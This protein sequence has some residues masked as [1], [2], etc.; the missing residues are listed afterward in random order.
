MADLIHTKIKNIIARFDSKF[1][2]IIFLLFIS[3]LVITGSIWQG[4][5]NN[6]P[7]HWGLMLSN[8]KDLYE[9]QLPYKDI[10]IQYGIL[11]TLVH[12]F[13][14]FIGG[15][16]LNTIIIITAIFYAIG[17]SLLY[18]L[19]L[20]IAKE[21]F[22]AVFVVII[23]FLIHPIA[24]YPWPNYIAFPLLILGLLLLSNSYQKPRYL[25]YSGFSFGL[26]ILA[27]ENLALPIILTLFLC[28]LLE[29][30]ES[31]I[32]LFEKLKEKLNIF[33]GIL[34]P[35]I[36]FLIYLFS[37]ELFFY[38]TK[39]A[40]DV[41][42]IYL[43]EAFDFTG[44][45][46]FLGEMLSSMLKLDFRW[47][48]FFLLFAFNTYIIFRKIFYDDK[49][50]NNPAINFILISSLVFIS[51]TLHIPEIWRL[52]T[53]S[54]IG[55]IS[56]FIFLNTHKQLSIIFLLF[57]ILLS[58]TFFANSNNYFYPT[59]L[60]RD[61]SIS[62]ND[63]IPIFK[64]QRWPLKNIKYYHQIQSDLNQ[65]KQKKCGIKYHYNAHHDAFLQVLSPFKQYQIA[66]MRQISD[67]NEL[68]PD[69]NFTKKIHN[70]NDIIIF[71]PIINTQ[72]NKYKVPSGFTIYS[73]YE[74]PDAFF[75]E[76]N[77]FLFIT[78]PNKCID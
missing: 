55:I 56:L 74:I 25:F 78:V 37:N 57:A 23:S 34:F 15:K 77:Y 71:K 22:I 27:R 73:S 13:A 49:F 64:G 65:I 10:F 63:F 17:I 12:S 41:P 8:A 42:N 36:I 76:P 46:K 30:K 68:R 3:C 21:K 62:V 59:K 33:L 38:W 1:S 16:T 69:L 14:Y 9:G 48:F 51:L 61:R 5:Y 28:F 29:L 26:A 4:A 44:V 50:F 58:F 7:L 45:N 70:G 20:S 35:I 47:T 52:S 40:I 6:D 18:K 24:I 2:E 75:I 31:T 43:T 32:F 11:T 53:G 54:I 72:I 39:L 19:T 67:I 60:I 66:P